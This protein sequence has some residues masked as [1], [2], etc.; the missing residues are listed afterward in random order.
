VSTPRTAPGPSHGPAILDV[1]TRGRRLIKPGMWLGSDTSNGT[2][3]P[4]VTAA[5]RRA[6]KRAE[7]RLSAIK[8]KRAA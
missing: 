6:T 2:P 7:Q 8:A 4:E 3:Q 1:M 5:A